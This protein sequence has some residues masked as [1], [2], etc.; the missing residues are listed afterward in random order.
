[1][2][3]PYRSI[4]SDRKILN[5]IA[6]FTI[7]LAVVLLAYFFPQGDLKP[8]IIFAFLI[9]VF[10][11]YKFDFRIPI[12]YGLSLLVITA[13]LISQKLEDSAR[14]LP[15]L[16]YWILS[17]SVIGLIFDNYRKRDLKFNAGKV[18]ENPS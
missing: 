15:V 6:P 11:I 10:A 12:G 5:K 16:S 17:A 1:M 9:F 3:R 7:T 4:L 13:V 8:I 14:Q 2:V 18:E